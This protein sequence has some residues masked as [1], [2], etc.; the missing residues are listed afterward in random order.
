MNGSTFVMGEATLED[1]KRSHVQL[2]LRS[3][4]EKVLEN[5]RLRLLHTPRG[6]NATRAAPKFVNTMS[7]SRGLVGGA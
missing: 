3:S 5:Q 2:R 6:F 1:S 7:S 4:T